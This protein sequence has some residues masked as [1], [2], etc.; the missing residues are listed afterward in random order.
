M[1]ALRPC[2]TDADYEG[3]L[4]VRRAVLP[5]ERTASLE[6]LKHS[7]RAGDLHIL[8]EL[9]GELAGS[10][11]SN[12]SDTGNA[13]LA[14]RVLPERRGRGVG[15]T[16]LK[17]LGEHA[18]GQG[19]R[20]ASSFVAGDDE[21]SIAFAMR[22]G[23]E[24][25]RRDVQQV[26]D[27]GSVSPSEIQG[28]EFSSIE[29]RPDLLEAAYPLA[30]QGYA[31]MP[32][33]GLA[34]S[35][36]SWMEEATLPAGSFAALADGEV[37]GYAGLMRWGDDP[38]K[39][40]HGLTVVRRDWRRRGLATALK[41]RQIAWAAATGVRRLVTYTQTGNE[42]MQAVNARLG[43]VTTEVTVAFTRSLPL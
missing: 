13:H 10:G 43:Y 37:V 25:T 26:L 4:A 31:D 38:T 11:L 28:V 21:R 35:V 40:E 23:F 2:E 8:A 5:N 3:W 32:I 16:L 1:I 24:Q 9:D 14:P 39:A 12:R 7:I 6:E 15:T 36:D 41:E 42:N 22:F 20:R 18:V 29:E 34:I 27:I 17:R 19:Y 33:E 30:Q